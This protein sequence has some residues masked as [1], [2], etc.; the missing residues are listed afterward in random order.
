V[1]FVNMRPYSLVDRGID[2]VGCESLLCCNAQRV[3]WHGGFI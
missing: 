3:I 1:A 2:Q